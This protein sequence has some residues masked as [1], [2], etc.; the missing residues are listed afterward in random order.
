MSDKSIYEKQ[1]SAKTV[2]ARRTTDMTTGS[3][4]IHLLKFT[5]PLLIG[6][7]FQ[8]LYN[9]V[10]SAVVGNY[11]GPDA[12]AAVGTCGSIHFLMFS[13]CQGLASGIGV[14]VAQC[15]GAKNHT[16]VKAAISSSFVIMASVSLFVTMLG[17]LLAAPILHLLQVPD[18]IFADAQVYLV[19]TLSGIIAI[20]FYN[21]TSSILRALGDSRTPLYFLILASIVNVGLDLLFVLVFKLGVFGVGLATILSQLAAAVTS[22]VYAFKKVEYFHFAKGEMKPDMQIVKK[23][24]TIG[25]PLA[26]QGALI[27]VSCMVLQGVV[28]TFGKTVIAANTIEGRIE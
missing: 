12:L 17:L 19:T 3:P 28:N 1:A 11:V 16:K 7:I 2:T 25:I 14:I 27:A 4:A 9:M 8:Q 22:L 10:D 26:L 18:A 5:W 20:S 13:L 24:F 6:N 21:G 23:T 15:F